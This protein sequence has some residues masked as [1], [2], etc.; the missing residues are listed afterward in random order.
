MHAFNFKDFKKLLNKIDEINKILGIRG[1]FFSKN[2]IPD[3]KQK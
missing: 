1:K 2:D 3:Q